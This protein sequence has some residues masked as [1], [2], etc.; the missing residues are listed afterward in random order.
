M[1][2]GTDP[3][4]DRKTMV[5]EKI[6]PKSLPGSLKWKISSGF[7]LAAVVLKNHC[8][9]HTFSSNF[10]SMRKSELWNFLLSPVTDP[11]IRGIYFEELI[12]LTLNISR[13]KKE[14]VALMVCPL[15]YLKKITEKGNYEVRNLNFLFEFKIIES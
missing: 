13:K 10:Y 3:V 7:P 15:A 1:E 6:I 5:M 9:L 14:E 8:H 2:S 11:R 4:I 12:L